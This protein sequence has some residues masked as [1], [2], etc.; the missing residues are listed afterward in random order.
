MA[1]NEL[2]S[3]V[4]AQEAYDQVKQLKTDINDLSAT[5]KQASKDAKGA[6]GDLKSDGQPF[7]AVTDNTNKA[8]LANKTLVDSMGS[9]V[10]VFSKATSIMAEYNGHS[11]EVISNMKGLTDVEKKLE[12][13]NSR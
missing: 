4:V 11:K 9:L 6:F 3:D 12:E 1:A 7:K 8:N 2:I 10:G 5:I 13:A